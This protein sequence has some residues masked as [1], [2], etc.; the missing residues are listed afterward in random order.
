MKNIVNNE[1]NEHKAPQKIWCGGGLGFYQYHMN[2]PFWGFKH[3]HKTKSKDYD[4]PIE[5]LNKDE[6]I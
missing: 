5:D 1:E 6:F 3:L 4:S 2:L